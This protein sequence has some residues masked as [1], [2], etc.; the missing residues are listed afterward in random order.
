MRY[1]TTTAC[2]EMKI[3]YLVCIDEE[4]TGYP[5]SSL[6]AAK[7]AYMGAIAARKKVEIRLS[8]LDA[9]LRENP[10]EVQ[11]WYYD[12]D[13]DGGTWVKA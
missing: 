4:E 11:R 9:G 10:V 13:L 12:Y 8:E 2:N 7:S 6:D 1:Y 5:H 3:V